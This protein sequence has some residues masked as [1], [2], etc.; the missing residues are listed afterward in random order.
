LRNGRAPPRDK[1]PIFFNG[2]K[3]PKKTRYE[4]P[5]SLF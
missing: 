5:I 2:N 3:Q 1:E 4:P